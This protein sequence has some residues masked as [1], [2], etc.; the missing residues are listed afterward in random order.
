MMWPLITILLLPH[1]SSATLRCPDGRSCPDKSTCCKLQDGN[2]GCCLVEEVGFSILT[3][4]RRP[5]KKS[6]TLGGS[7][8]SNN[9]NVICDYTSFCPDG[10]I[11]CRKYFGLWSCCP[12][13][14]T[15]CCYF[16][17]KCCYPHHMKNF[18]PSYAAQKYPSNSVEPKTLQ[19]KEIQISSIGPSVIYCDSVNFCPVGNTCCRLQNGNWGCCPHP[20]AECCKDDAHCCPRG[21]KCDIQSSK[22]HMDSFSIP[23][24][25]KKP[26]LT[27]SEA[28]LN[29]N[30]SDCPV[31]Q[32][33]DTHVCKAGSTCC[34]MYNKQWGCCPFPKAHCCWDK[35][36]C[37][38]KY[39]I[40]DNIY[41]ICRKW[42]PSHDWSQLS[43][44]K[45]DD[46]FENL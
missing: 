24:V 39:H 26:A 21:T 8:S 37:C 14:Q 25:S 10:F 12:Y 46:E 41:H 7:V 45:Y 16:G 2:Y 32:C 11:C 6:E 40:C 23:W 27:V 17:E 33:D 9:L 42:I 35:K 34:K 3:Q 1:L 28:Q 38:P 22:C 43:S 18:G 30:N 13:P 4:S 15:V 31:V 20:E 36:H 19:V 29:C 5:V 44:I